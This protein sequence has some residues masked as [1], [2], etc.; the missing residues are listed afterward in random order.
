MLNSPRDPKEAKVLVRLECG[1]FMAMVVMQLV[2]LVLTCVV[3]NCWVRE[4]EGLE[5]EKEASARKRSRRIAR[6]QEESLANAAKIAEVKAKELD[7]I[8]KMRSKYVRWVKTDF[9]G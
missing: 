3:H 6:V 2:V 4:Y 1:V 8:E 7:E 5:A 9:E